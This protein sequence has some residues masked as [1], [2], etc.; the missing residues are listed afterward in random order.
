MAK[1]VQFR[2]TDDDPNITDDAVFGTTWRDTWKF[3]CPQH[4]VLILKPEDIF[5]AY[6]ED[7]GDAEIAAPDALVK[8]EVRDPS[9]QRIELVFGPD[10][11]ISSSNFQEMSNRRKL[12]IEHKII[13]NPRDWIVIATK[14]NTGLDAASIL[15]SYF[16][17]I[18]SKVIEG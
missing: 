12:R 10:N 16:E 1:E 11:Y 17:L 3:R 9:E 2:L 7:S 5:S 14:D 18:T 15:N 13:V 4:M 6:I 8:V